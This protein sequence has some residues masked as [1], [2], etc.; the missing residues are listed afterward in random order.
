VDDAD[1][2][3]GIADIDGRVFMLVA[4]KIT[5]GPQRYGDAWRFDTTP[6]LPCRSASKRAPSANASTKHGSAQRD[7]DGFTPRFG[8]SA[9]IWPFDRR[10][11]PAAVKHDMPTTAP[12]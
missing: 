3:G 4:E 11:R 8:C 9:S 6:S 10:R 12:K 1:V 5:T 2:M 7:Y